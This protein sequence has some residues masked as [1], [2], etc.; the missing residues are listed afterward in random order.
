MASLIST[1][2]RAAWYLKWRVL[3]NQTEFW[4][5][6]FGYDMKKRS[7]DGWGY[8]IY[9]IIFFI[10]WIFM[11]LLLLANIGG[12]LLLALPFASQQEA[13]AAAGL[14]GFLAFFLLELYQ[15]SRRSPF[16][17]SEAD[18]YILCLTPLNRR[19]VV[20]LWFTIAWLG[21][22]MILWP[23]GIVLGYALYEAQTAV[24]FAFSDLPY[25]ILSG[26][27]M[28]AVII[29][30][31]LAVQSLAWAAGAW[32]LQGKRDLP[33]LKWSA[34]LLL[35]LFAGSFILTAQTGI[36]AFTSWTWP[37]HFPI[38][39]GLGDAPFLVGIFAA[40]ILAF[41]GLS[42]L[43]AAAPTISLARASQETRSRESLH[44]AMLTG[45]A[46][47]SQELKQ[48]ERL[49]ASRKP[50]RLPARSGPA[51]LLWRN[52]IQAQRT[53]SI[54]K[55]VNW[56]VIF[57]L[58]LGVLMTQ[59]WGGRAF[60]ASFW[61]AAASQQAAESIK[62]DLKKWWL[63]RQL[64]V[65]S[66]QTLIMN[67]LPPGVGITLAAYSAYFTARLLDPG[68][69]PV[70]GWLIL[71]ASIGVT[72]I[73]AIGI[74]EYCQTEQLISGIVPSLRLPYVLF[75]SLMLAAM[76]GAAW[77]LL[78]YANMILWI[79]TP[80]LIILFITIDYSLYRLAGSSLRD[81]K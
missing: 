60:I 55:L 20:M 78:S 13:A 56:L 25:Y 5:V 19:S 32:R 17:F 47:Y 50:A 52:T 12:Q 59:D 79:G 70:I 72:L 67:L 73:A 11:V 30:L 71:P 26:M 38:Q 2:L 15:A 48:R 7:F 29:P 39:A 27:R 66:Y 63:L 61:V 40:I 42:L 81:I 41:A 77:F 75:G 6:L 1:D 21:R 31:H 62:K 46:S 49:G 58:G 35:I 65:S 4:L 69:T 23:G 33:T 10:I 36:A 18:S 54:G 45:D 28:L 24:E 44:L 3:F 74:L 37:L 64:P 51:S 43:A 57:G 9:V 76:A 68:I 14:I 53:V 22:A 8:L 16:V 34:P 80:L